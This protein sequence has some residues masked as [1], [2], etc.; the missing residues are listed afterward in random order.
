MTPIPEPT[1][2]LVFHPVR[3]SEEI[4]ALMA[5]VLDGT[6]D[7]HSKGRPDPDV[8]P[9][10]RGQALRGRARALPQPAGWW[11]IATLPD[12]EPGGVD[13]NPI[14]GYLAVLPEHRGNGYIDEIVAEGA[15]ILSAQNVP[16]IRAAT[17]LGNTP[18]ATPS[19]AADT[20]T[21]DAR[22]P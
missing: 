12:G 5:R 20:S 2:R 18:M 11:R 6:L 4:L 15:R 10:G 8:R 14:I 19:S 13:Y 7:A 9:R 16:H 1:G 3:D 17:D 22:S 21:S